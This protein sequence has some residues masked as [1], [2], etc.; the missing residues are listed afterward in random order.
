MVAMS[1]NKGTKVV[2]K[3]LVLFGAMM[4]CASLPAFGQGKALA[5]QP[6]LQFPNGSGKDV[7][8]Q[9]CG[10][11]HTP[12]N[13]IGK[14]YTEDGWT[15]LMGTMVDKGAQMS[16]DQ[17][18]AILQYLMTNFGP[19]PDKI[20]VN[21]ATVLNLRNWM[22]LSQ[23]QAEALINYRAQNGDFK[24]IDDLKKV[25]GIDPAIYEAKKNRLA[26]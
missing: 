2:S 4:V 18:S 17:F 24:S 5:E 10:Q 23:Q 22:G 14:G 20:N 1:N 8:L 19:P 13:V 15:Q 16:E 21:K 6:K 3:R 26:F 25:A 11:C 7:F 9:I 12:E